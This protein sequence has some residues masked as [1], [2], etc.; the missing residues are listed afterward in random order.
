VTVELFALNANCMH[1][2][3]MPTVTIR[4]VPE[5]VRDS[6]AKEARERGQSLQAF[7]LSLLR[8]QATFG[9]NTQLLLQVERDLSAGDGAG[10]EAPDAADLID[11]A[12]SD[13]V[14]GVGQKPG[15]RRHV[16]AS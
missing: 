14:V 9:R 12:R 13:R 10:P 4:D 3:S 15:T 2:E 1:N 16:R 8:R 7:L 6:L 11:K 5:D